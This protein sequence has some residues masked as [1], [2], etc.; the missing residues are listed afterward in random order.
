[1][2]HKQKL[3]LG[4]ESNDAEDSQWSCDAMSGSDEDHVAGD[5]EDAAG[6]RKESRKQPFG[7]WTVSEIVRKIDGVEVHVGYGGNCGQHFGV[8][9]IQQLFMTSI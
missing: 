2:A 6:A 7:P 8:A 1:M 4:G 5:A 3:P 9:S